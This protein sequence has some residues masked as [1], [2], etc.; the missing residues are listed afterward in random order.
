MSYISA[1][2]RSLV[3]ERAKG[4]CEYCRVHQDDGYLVHEIDHVVSEKHRGI[5]SADN[6]CLS[7]FECNRY[8]GSDIGSIDL[9]TD[10]FTALF[11]PRTMS[12]DDHFELD[13]VNIK[14]LTPEGRVTV[15]LL[16]LNNDSRI[17]R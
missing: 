3:I 9:E 13:S 10:S 5:T 4:Y 15:F 17:T 11:N 6:L 16:R 8:K 14:P 1:E 7:C 2:L 12:W